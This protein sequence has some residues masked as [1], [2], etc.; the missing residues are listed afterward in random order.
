MKITE[1]FKIESPVP[2]VDVDTR[3]DTLY[4]CQPFWIFRDQS[5]ND[6]TRI[7]QRAVESFDATWVQATLRSNL[8][9]LHEFF[10]FPEPHEYRLG[11]SRTSN[12]GRGSGE[13]R[14][15]LMTNALRTKLSLLVRTGIFHQY[16]ALGL[17]VEKIGLDT[18]SDMTLTVVREALIRFT[19]EMMLRYP[20]LQKDSSMHTFRIWNH[21]HAAWIN[22]DAVVPTVQGKPLLLV[23]EIWGDRRFVIAAGPFY[24]KVVSEHLLL[25]MPEIN[26]HPRRKKIFYANYPFDRDVSRTT[27]L[28]AFEQSGSDLVSAF[29][30]IQEGLYSEPLKLI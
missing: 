30:K 9:R 15:S 11:Y 28:S 23:P 12:S 26:N 3:K 4:F 18:V 7:A 24:A 19:Q 16:E 20:S 6:Y 22:I 17:F 10:L 5:S 21:E 1:I 14:A 25:E 13:L 27:T 2:F 8:K 29:Y